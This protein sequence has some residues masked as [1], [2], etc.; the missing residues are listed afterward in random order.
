MHAWHAITQRQ[1]VSTH[2]EWPVRGAQIPGWHPV[3]TVQDISPAPPMAVSI[4][5]GTIVIFCVVGAALVVAELQCMA[6]AEGGVHCSVSSDSD[7]LSN[8]VSTCWGCLAVWW[9]LGMP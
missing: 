1:Y 7:T 2:G 6:A 8:S 9:Q 3:V 4:C 5:I